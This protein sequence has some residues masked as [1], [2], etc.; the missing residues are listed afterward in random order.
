M[1]NTSL[2]DVLSNFGRSTG[3]YWSAQNNQFEQS[4]P[5]LGNRLLRSFN[6]MTGFGSALGAMHDGANQGSERDMLIAAAQ[7]YP[8]WGNA[9][10]L[11]TLSGLRPDMAAWGAKAFGGGIASG[12]VDQAQAADSKGKK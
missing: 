4:N 6:P 9:K 7:A 10:M 5:H 8:L 2:M 1:N 11:K 3:E 12:L